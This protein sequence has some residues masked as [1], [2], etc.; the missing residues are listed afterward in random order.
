MLTRRALL[1]LLAG[2][3]DVD[4]PVSRVEPLGRLEDG[5]VLFGEPGPPVPFKEFFKPGK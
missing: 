4:R 2:R 3:R 1:R 5:R